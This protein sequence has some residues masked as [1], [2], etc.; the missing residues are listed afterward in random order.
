MKFL[1]IFL[2]LAPIFGVAQTDSISN[3]FPLKDG[4]VIYETIIELP[5]ISKTI[6]Y[7]I[8]KKW[9]ADT[10][11][12]SNAVIQSEDISS[13]QIVGK[14]LNT[15]RVKNLD[16]KQFD[17]ECTFQIDVKENKCRIRFYNI[18]LVFT[19]LDRTF[20]QPLEEIAKTAEDTNLKGSKRGHRDIA[21][22]PNSFNAQYEELMASYR[23]AMRKGSKDVF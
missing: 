6:L 22:K 17:S 13:G 21:E 9:I 18:I 3:K 10:F 12:N 2:L 23:E 4:K 11:K 5:N 14:G 15:V 16:V 20:K 19:A 7:G 8:S 1:F